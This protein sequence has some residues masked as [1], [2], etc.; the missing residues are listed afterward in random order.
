MLIAYLL[1][2]PRSSYA[3]LAL[4]KSVHYN[5]HA[6]E[7]ACAHFE[8]CSNQKSTLDRAVAYFIAKHILVCGANNVEDVSAF[9]FVPNMTIELSQ[10]LCQAV[11]LG[12][13]AK[14]VKLCEIKE[15][16]QAPALQA[17][18]QAAGS[19]KKPNLSS[20][21]DCIHHEATITKLCCA[22][23]LLFRLASFEDYRDLQKPGDFLRQSQIYIKF[24]YPGVYVF[25]G[26]R[27]PFGRGG[28]GNC[29]R[30]HD[31]GGRDNSGGWD[32]AGWL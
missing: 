9:G 18:E 5:S 22:L 16:E 30:G 10:R 23:F 12:I 21:K 26:R 15:F 7:L 31:D 3:W 27:Q 28:G 11:I 19:N 8:R 24:F 25:S 20:K 32:A 29:G 2:C 6:V 1:N 4:G 14:I 17:D 13:S